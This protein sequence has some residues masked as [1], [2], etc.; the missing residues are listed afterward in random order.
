MT[1]PYPFAVEMA[2]NRKGANWHI[3]KK[4]KTQRS[5]LQGLRDLRKDSTNK[6]FK[7]RPIHNE[8]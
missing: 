7:F 8:K 5:C 6:S 4:Y 1:C 3:W 2:V